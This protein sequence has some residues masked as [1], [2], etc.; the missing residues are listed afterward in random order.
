MNFFIAVW[1]AASFILPFAGIYSNSL[2]HAAQAQV[3][4]QA[5]LLAILSRCFFPV[6]VERLHDSPA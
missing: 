1:A 2:S 4:A 3:K 5:I 6:L